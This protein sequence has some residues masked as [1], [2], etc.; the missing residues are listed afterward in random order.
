MGLPEAK[1]GSRA[2]ELSRFRCFKAGATQK[3]SGLQDISQCFWIIL[4]FLVWMLKLNGGLD[5]RP[6]KETTRFWYALH[7]PVHCDGEVHIKAKLQALAGSQL[8]TRGPLTKSFGFAVQGVRQSCFCF[9][10][11]GSRLGGLRNPGAM[12]VAGTPI[13]FGDTLPLALEVGPALGSKLRSE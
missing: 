5:A 2:S 8:L 10:I 7:I 1:L 13:S 9:A 4:R 6:S 3:G 11:H 12:V